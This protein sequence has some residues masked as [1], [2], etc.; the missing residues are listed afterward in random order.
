MTEEEILEQKRPAL[1]Q[2]V[3]ECLMAWANI[4]LELGMVF[5]SAVE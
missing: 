4:E 2:A 5:G 3:G 1:T